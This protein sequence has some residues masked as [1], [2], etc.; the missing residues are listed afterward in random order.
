MTVLH[1]PLRHMQLSEKDQL[2]RIEFWRYYMGR[3]DMLGWWSQEAG[4]LRAGV[5]LLDTLLTR[6]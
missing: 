4:F 3:S 6:W 1:S 2:D 5:L